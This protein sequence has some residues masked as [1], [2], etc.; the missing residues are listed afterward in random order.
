MPPHSVSILGSRTV[1]LP[2]CPSLCLSCAKLGRWPTLLSP[3]EVASPN[4]AREGEEKR[5]PLSREARF[6]NWHPEFRLGTAVRPQ[7]GLV[8]SLP[9]DHLKSGLNLT[10]SQAGRQTGRQEGS[11]WG[12][13]CTVF[14]LATRGDSK[15]AAVAGEAERRPS[16]SQMSRGAS[17]SST[18]SS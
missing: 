12:I 13:G 2:V 1:C 16:S 3:F 4:Q 15:S 11:R 8:L 6:L 5:R 18:G 17:A 9:F 10:S 7:A 14:Y